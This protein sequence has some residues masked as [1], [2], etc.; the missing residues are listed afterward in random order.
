MRNGWI[1]QGTLRLVI[2]S[3][4]NSCEGCWQLE[5][6]GRACVAA[7]GPQRQDPQADAAQELFSLSSFL[8]L[9]ACGYS[10]HYLEHSPGYGDAE[11]KLLLFYVAKGNRGDTQNYLQRCILPSP[12]SPQNPPSCNKDQSLYS[13][14]PP[15]SFLPT[16]FPGSRLQRD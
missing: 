15:D 10:I 13:S 12:S 16:G 9:S 2:L 7:Q 8:W 4:T 11:M 6:Q 1:Q 5:P 3:G 14:V